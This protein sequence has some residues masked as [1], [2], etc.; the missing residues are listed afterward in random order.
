MIL[1]NNYTNST[2]STTYKSTANHATTEV[3]QLTIFGHQISPRYQSCL[4]K[5][6]S[7]EQCL[8][9]VMN[10]IHQSEL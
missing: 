9:Q 1:G 2:I 5:K 4:M 7:A 3:T 10:W 6:P 8:S